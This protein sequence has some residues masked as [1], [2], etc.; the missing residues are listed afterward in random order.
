MRAIYLFTRLALFALGLYALYKLF[1]A[2]VI[3]N[4][5]TR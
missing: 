5:F 4:P 3:V 2:S 1:D